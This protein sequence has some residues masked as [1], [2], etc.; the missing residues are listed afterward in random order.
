MS[1]NRDAIIRK[2]GLAGRI[3]LDRPQALNAQFTS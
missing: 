2:E 3:T 1:G